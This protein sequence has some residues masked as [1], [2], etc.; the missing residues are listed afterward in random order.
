MAFGVSA[1]DRSGFAPCRIVFNEITERAIKDGYQEALGLSI[2]SLVDA[3]QAQPR[4]GQTGGISDKS[5]SLEKGDEEG[6][7]RRKS[8]VRRISR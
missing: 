1:G 8:T 2:S 7:V 5:A 3:Q 4:T 6:L